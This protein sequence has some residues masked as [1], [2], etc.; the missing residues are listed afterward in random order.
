MSI[1]KLSFDSATDANTIKELLDGGEEN[2]SKVRELVTKSTKPLRIVGTKAFVTPVITNVLEGVVAFSKQSK[3]PEACA[4]AIISLLF[5]NA[6]L[7]VFF[8]TYLELH[9]EA[10]DNAN[11]TTENLWKFLINMPS[12]KEHLYPLL[13]C[14]EYEKFEFTESR[15][16]AVF[17]KVWLKQLYRGI[18]QS[19]VVPVLRKLTSSVMAD[20]KE[21]EMLGDFLT[22]FIERPGTNYGIFAL[23]GM[24]RLMLT[25]NFAYPHFFD[26]LYA[27]LPAL[28]T[29]PSFEAV[30]FV[31]NFDSYMSSTHIPA[32]I[33]AG[34]VKRVSRICL[35][36]S[37]DLISV[38]LPSLR[39]MFINH[40]VVQELLHRE[41]PASHESDPYD[42]TA[43]LKDCRAM[44]SSLWELSALFRHWNTDI[45]SKVG[46]ADSKIHP[47]SDTNFKPLA[48]QDVF[49]RAYKRKTEN[50]AIADPRLLA[51]A[52]PK[53]WALL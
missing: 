33:V 4:R 43:S 23:E 45:V 40:Q 51:A 42:E 8:F 46:W 30:E 14:K 7:Y 16:C 44:E 48:T 27:K 26:T 24:A 21:P 35:T 18:P 12:P 19:M 49:N 29:F 52:E 9:P 38:L 11:A 41:Q 50:I 13:Y 25:R 53:K 6:D 3:V 32:Y 5:K 31:G 22:A 20:F 39:N 17:E 28:V 15:R 10:L 2:L 34:V 1:E 37:V 36:A 47:I